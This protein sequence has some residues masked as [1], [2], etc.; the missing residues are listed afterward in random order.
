MSPTSKG[1]GT[2][3]FSSGVGSEEPRSSLGLG[4]GWPS[5]GVT[6]MLVEISTGWGGGVT[7]S[8]EGVGEAFGVPGTLLSV[9]VGGK[10]VNRTIRPWGT[11]QN[12]RNNVDVRIDCDTCAGRKVCQY[13][14]PN[15]NIRKLGL[16]R[17]RLGVFSNRV[18]IAKGGGTHPDFNC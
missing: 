15:E 5:I 11:Y 4:A 12:H 9:Y 8:G 14:R 7:G 6:T 2:A 10:S 18:Y 1:V 16:Q 3:G 13:D 17:V